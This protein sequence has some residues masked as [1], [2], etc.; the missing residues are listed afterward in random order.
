MSAGTVFVFALAF[1]FGFLPS[2]VRSYLVGIALGRFSDMSLMAAGLIAVPIVWLIALVLS[3]GRIHVR[4][5][6]TPRAAD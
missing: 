4:R 3:R 6:A 2:Q 1:A 5:A